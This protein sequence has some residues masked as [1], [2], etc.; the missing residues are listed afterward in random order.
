MVTLTKSKPQFGTTLLELEHAAT[1]KGCQADSF[2]MDWKTL[3]AQLASYP[4]PV[5]VPTQNPEPHFSVLLAVKDGTVYMADP[6][7]GYIMLSEKAFLKR[8]LIAKEETGFAFIAIGSEGYVNENK[9]TQVLKRLF[10]QT[11]NLQ[12]MQLYSP[13]FRR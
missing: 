2:R 13:T 8:W 7:T 9:R 4:L 10:K 12:S 5:I 6:A 1:Q 11:E 3:K